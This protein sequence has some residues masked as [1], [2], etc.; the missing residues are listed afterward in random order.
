MGDAQDCNSNSC[1]VDVSQEEKNIVTFVDAIAMDNDLE[2]A[3]EVGTI[4]TNDEPII[5]E[6]DTKYGVDEL[7][8]LRDNRIDEG[9]PGAF[10]KVEVKEV[11]EKCIS[12][13]RASHIIGVLKGEENAIRLH[14]ITRI[15]GYYSRTTS[16]NKSKIGELRDRGQGIYKLKGG[17]TNSQERQTAI[18]AL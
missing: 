1:T 15:V 9:S 5:A 12:M 18:N 6:D 17:E 2:F 14:G 16:W 7:F 13:E 4:S 11:M 8:V 10:P 3:G